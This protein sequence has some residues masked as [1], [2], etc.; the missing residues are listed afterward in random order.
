MKPLK[1]PRILRAEHELRQRGARRR[2]RDLRAD[3]L[4]RRSGSLQRGGPAYTVAIG[5]L[6]HTPP[7]PSS[8]SGIS[9]VTAFTKEPDRAFYGCEI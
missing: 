1:E 8:F 6:A 2:D 7:A 5:P 4:E 9:R 3:C